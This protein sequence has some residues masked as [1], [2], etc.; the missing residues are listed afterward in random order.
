MPWKTESL[1]LG[2]E[3]KRTMMALASTLGQALSQMPYPSPL[4]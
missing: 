1:T 4:I 3:G 2:A